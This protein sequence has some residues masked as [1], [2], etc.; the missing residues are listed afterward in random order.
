LEAVSPSDGSLSTSGTEGLE[1]ICALYEATLQFLSLAYEAIAGSWYDVAD[2]T[3]VTGSSVYLAISKIFTDITSP[4]ALHQASFP[5]LEKLHSSISQSH[6]TKDIQQS[7]R[8]SGSLSVAVLQDTAEKLKGLSTFVF[9]IGE[10][11]LGR[12]ELMTGGYQVR[13]SLSTIDSILSNHAGE[14]AIAIRTLSA[15]L[16]ARNFADAFDDQHVSSS[17]E[18]LKVVGLYQ[19]SLKQFETKTHERMA[20]LQQR[21][22]SYDL[23]EKDAIDKPKAFLLPDSL[24][25]VEIDSILTK[26]VFADSQDDQNTLER[27]AASDSL[28]FPESSDAFDRLK[29]SCQTFVFDICAA[30]PF[31][32]LAKISSMPCWSSVSDSVD[33]YGTLPQSYITHVGEH[34]LALVQ[35][36]DPFASCTTSLAIAKEVMSSVRDVALQPWK[37]LLAAVGFSNDSIAGVLM[38]GSEL[39]EY[40]NSGFDDEDDLEDDEQDAEE[41]SK[42]DFSNQWLD[43]VG[44]AVTGR[45]LER[46]LRIPRVSVK[47]CDHLSVDLNYLAN[48]L[49]ALGVNGHPHPLVNHFAEI[50]VLDTDALTLLIQSRVSNTTLIVALRTIEERV[51]QMRGVTKF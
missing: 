41:R 39:K 15:N 36:L 44:L 14:L 51:A 32:H 23:Q 1:S 50:F 6:V 27:L 12:L 35:A 26:S 47:G 9:P 10:A 4:F 33:S 13:K 30:V 8:F 25:I 3:S 22:I 34:M 19:S 38:K 42:H 7:V 11:A 24:S 17:L 20:V 21:K 16:E 46:I 31:Q 40:V 48:V 28:L 29:R 18:I 43:V 45:L 2:A 37:D 5:S 49:A